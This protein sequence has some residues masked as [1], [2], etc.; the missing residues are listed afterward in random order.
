MNEKIRKTLYVPIWI[1]EMLDADGELYGGPGVIVSA[2]ILKFYNLDGKQKKEVLREYRNREITESPFPD[3]KA[4]VE[5]A[6]AQSGGE[7]RKSLK[8]VQSKAAG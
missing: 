3:A 6:V 1:G 8:R 5:R 4:V 7:M 2:A